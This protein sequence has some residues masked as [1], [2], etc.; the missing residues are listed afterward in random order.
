M[1]SFLIYIFIPKA[2]VVDL[3]TGVNSSFYHTFYPKKWGQLKHKVNLYTSI[4][5][6]FVYINEI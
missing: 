3:Y 1:S 4:Y 6:T 5:G 2:E